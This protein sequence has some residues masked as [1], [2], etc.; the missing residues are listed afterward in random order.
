[1]NFIQSL[2]PQLFKGL[3]ELNDIVSEI[4]HRKVDHGIALFFATKII[5]YW[6]LTEHQENILN[7]WIERYVP[8]KYLL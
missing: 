7:S 2:Y 4:L 5:R 1:V 8:E 3:D 6:H